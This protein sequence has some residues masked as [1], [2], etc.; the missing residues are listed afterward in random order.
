MRHGKPGMEDYDRFNYLKDSKGKE[1]MYDNVIKV[2]NEFK[3]HPAV[4]T[5]GVG[6]EVYLNMST[7]EEKLAYS[8][9]LERIC[10]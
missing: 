6:N 2:V 3:N 10:S 7:D 5:W 4:L 9:L 8:N 1:A